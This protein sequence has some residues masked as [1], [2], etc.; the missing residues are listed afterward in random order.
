MKGDGISISGLIDA[1]HE[2]IVAHAEHL[3]LLDSAIGDGDHGTNMLRGCDA[4]VEKRKVF[5]ALPL[6]EALQQVGTTLVMTIGGAAGP[7]YA[8]LLIE[9]GQRLADPAR[10]S[11]LAEDF[12]IAVEAVARRGRSTRGQ[13]TLLD[14]L[15]PVQE[16][17][18][19]HGS[20]SQ[21]ADG[22]GI[23]AAGTTDMKAMRGRASF[24]GERSIGH[25]DPG[26][27]SCA[28]LIQAV[29]RYLEKERL[30]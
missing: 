18:V 14:V 9:L 30:P 2:A 16:E 8:T 7:L 22:A 11:V 5:E 21:I 25:M 13:K 6:A 17:M 27:A 4:V 19:R 24:L 20:F 29:C 1:C 15:Y 23:A 26:A 3:C 10:N 12:G 28:L